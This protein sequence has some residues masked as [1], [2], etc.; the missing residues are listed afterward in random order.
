M[1]SIV[2]TGRDRRRKPPYPHP[3]RL[4]SRTQEAAQEDPEDDQE[5]IESPSTPTGCQGGRQGLKEG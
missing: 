3:H 1:Q 5:V 4:P 2:I